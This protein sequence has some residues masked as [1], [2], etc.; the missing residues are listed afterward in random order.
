MRVALTLALAV[1]LGVGCTTAGPERGAVHGEVPT[2]EPGFTAPEGFRQTDS[3][4]DPYPDHIG[5]RLSFRD[6]TGKELHYFAGI[7]GEFGEG[8]P[9]RGTVT[10]AGEIAGTL[11][12]SADVW[13]LTWRAPGLCGVRAVLGSGFTRRG[14]V[15]TL[16][17]AAIIPV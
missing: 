10:A 3:L 15:D 14:F 9:V 17:E 4:Q 13:V 11:Q 7:P 12:G 2:C 16:R 6:E 8:L 1:V 5:I